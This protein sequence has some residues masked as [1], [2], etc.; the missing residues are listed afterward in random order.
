MIQAYNYMQQSL[1]VK[2]NVKYPV[3]KRSE[4]KKVYDDIVSLSKRSPL[5]KVNLSKENQEYTFGV[6]E[7]ALALKAKIG[8]MADP[9]VSGFKSK[10][11]VVSDEKALAAKLLSENTEGIPDH[12]VFQVNNLASVQINR[13]R[14]LLN[15]SKGLPSG[16][17]KFNAIIGDE[18]YSLAF[19][20]E[21]RKENK[22]TLRNFAEF[23]NRSIPGISAVVEDGTV[24]DY[25]RLT[26]ASDTSGRF[27]DK[28]FVFEDT[29]IYNE[30]ITEFFGMNRM[31]KA[32]SYAKFELNGVDKQTATNAFTLENTLHINLLNP[33]EQSISLKIVPDQGKILNS[34]M[35]V[36]TTFNG[37]IKIAKNRT[38]DSKDHY[39]A[40]K[41]IGE[42]KSLENV[43]QEELSACGLKAAEDGSIYLEDSLAVQAAEDGGMESLFTRENGF[44]ARLLDKAE[45]IAINPMEYL[46]KT[47]V[48]YPDSNKSGYRNPYVTSMYSGMFFNS[49]C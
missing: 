34:V 38:E 31:E 10:T 8:D 13:G 21:T 25:S 32:P 5:Y 43:Y 11:V 41:L 24:K 35:E 39:K 1:P 17:Y 44:I 42:M 9:K 19:E 40:T 3:S 14:E 22:D 37:L 29:D 7:S 23:L 20:H 47:I 18:T 12:I 36:F 26:L 4:L 28:R 15:T 2:R 30:G 49:Y 46:D 16:E 45:T 33:S 48:T 27:G 6:K